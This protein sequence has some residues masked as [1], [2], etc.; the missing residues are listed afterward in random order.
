MSVFQG[1]GENPP[2]NIL[3]MDVLMPQYQPI[4]KP[5][6]YPQTIHRNIHFDPAAG[7]PLTE[8]TQAGWDQQ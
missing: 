1:V 4:S 5:K 2:H 7:V 3:T 8:K 6:I